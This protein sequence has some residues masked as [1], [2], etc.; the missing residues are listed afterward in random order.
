MPRPVVELAVLSEQRAARWRLTTQI[1]QAPAARPHRAR[2]RSTSL[3]HG[4]RAAGSRDLGTAVRDWTSNLG[5]KGRQERPREQA[6]TALAVRREGSDGQAPGRTRGRLRRLLLRLLPPPTVHGKRRASQ[7]RAVL[8][9]PARGADRSAAWAVWL[10][11]AARRLYLDTDQATRCQG[12]SKP[13]KEACGD[14]FFGRH[15]RFFARLPLFPE[16]PAFP[17]AP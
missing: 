4:G 11:R 15:L 17:R 10:A 5:I 7:L 6:A 8:W 13:P 12:P 14:S 16:P 9:S 1:L 3:C 2:P